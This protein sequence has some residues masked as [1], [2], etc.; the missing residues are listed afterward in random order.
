MMILAC[1]HVTFNIDLACLGKR[2]LL[3]LSKL[4]DAPKFV[5]NT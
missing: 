3:A 5:V 1:D 2:N 4:Y